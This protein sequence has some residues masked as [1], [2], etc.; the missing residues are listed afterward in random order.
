MQDCNLITPPQRIS[1]SHWD[2]VWAIDAYEYYPGIAE[3][4]G[5]K[6]LSLVKLKGTQPNS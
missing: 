2:V 1:S 3:S 5:E 6:L 4:K